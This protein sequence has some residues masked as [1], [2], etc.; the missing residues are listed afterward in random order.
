M[1]ATQFEWEQLEYFMS[2]L[3]SPSRHFSRMIMSCNPSPDH[4]IRE[5]IS[6]YLTPD[7]Y[8]D[9]EKDGVVR[10]FIKEDTTFLWGDSR[11]ELGEKYGIPEEDWEDKILS[12]S[13][14][15][16]LI[17]DNPYM[18]KNNKSYVAFLEGLNEVDKAQLL[19]GNWDIRSKGA[20]YF[21]RG[22]LQEVDSVPIGA[23]CCRAYDFA[24]TERSQVNKSPDATTSVKMYRTKDNYYVLAGEYHESFID[25][26][27]SV[28]GRV[29]KRIGDRDNV[30]IKQAHYDGADCYIV[31]PIDPAA[32]G[33]QVFTEFAKKMAALGFTVKRDPVPNNRAKLQRF[34]PFAD[35]AENGL[36]KI[37]KNTF[38]PVTYEF[39]MKEI[40]AFDGERSSGTRHDDFPD[41]V[42]SAYNFLCSAKVYQPVS[43]PVFN[44]SQTP[45]ARMKNSLN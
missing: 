22:W 8:A 2:R 21:E 30:V 20:N 43:I 41:C 23:V 28:M 33:K 27:T 4:K 7:G 34:L 35:A 37:A 31:S 10:Y 1:E 6:W 36:I 38:D 32:S 24:A 17:Y 29:C 18:L 11:K 42:A 25:D 14:V 40:E 12:F 13:F 26:E 15:S 16:G 45:Y 9:P 5:L 3:R 19:L 44:N 39:I